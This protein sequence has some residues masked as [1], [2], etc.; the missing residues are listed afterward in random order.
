MRSPSGTPV[1]LPMALHP[2]TQSWR[3]ICVLEGISRIDASEKRL[4][5]ATS[6]SIARFQLANCC[7]TICA[8]SSVPGS[9]LPFAGKTAEISRSAYSCAKAFFGVS[10]RCTR[11]V[12]ASVWPKRFLNQSLRVKLSQADRAISPAVPAA[13]F[14]KRRRPR[15]LGAIAG[16]LDDKPPGDHRAHI[17]GE[18]GDHDLYDVDD[19][20][21][22]KGKACQE[23]DRP[24]ALPAAEQMKQPGNGR[25]DR[26]RHAETGQ[27]DQRSQHEQHC[28]I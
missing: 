24:R 1:H 7:C 5:A 23:V 9:L 11:S 4:G 10:A 25:I 16:S 21:P 20:E 26:R 14:N 15:A 6:P 18:S 27:E 28:Q 17:I 19:D 3:V 22:D 12:S 8:Y 13:A 2:S